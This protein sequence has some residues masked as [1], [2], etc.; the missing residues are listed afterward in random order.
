MAREAA[1]HGRPEELMTLLEPELYVIDTVLVELVKQLRV[2][3]TERGNLLEEIRQQVLE[4]FSVTA[5]G[6]KQVNDL[7]LAES[8]ARA[9][10]ETRASNLDA[11]NA[12]AMQ[13]M[14]AMA[15]ESNALEERT[16][17]LLEELEQAK[18][19]SQV[20]NTGASK[21]RST[22]EIE[23]ERQL[24]QLRDAEELHRSQ[25]TLLEAQQHRAEQN[26]AAL[27]AHVL[28]LQER[29]R[30][31]AE[32]IECLSEEKARHKLRAMWLHTLVLLRRAPRERREAGT[33]DGDGIDRSFY[34]F[35]LRA[36]S[37]CALRL[38]LCL[39]VPVPVQYSQFDCF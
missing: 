7:H 38:Y 36:C 22:R 11:E 27:Q 1:L 3:C 24:Q 31:D 2:S 19:K 9:E 23:M 35:L 6:L 37:I 14:A 25:Y 32:E 4:I 10:L 5:M 29:V 28:D 8:K 20:T 39:S 33:Q 13:K 21:T 34:P 12:R 26:N 15:I 17:Q 16:K 30:R 18:R